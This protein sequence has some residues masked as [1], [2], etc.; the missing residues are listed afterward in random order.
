MTATTRLGAFIAALLLCSAAPLAA[1]E[2]WTWNRQ[3]AAGQV[4]EIKGVNGAI[5]AQPGTGS[6]VRVTAVKTARRDDVSTVRME[7]I[8]HAGGV[9][10]C[11]VYPAARGRPQNECAVGSGGRMNVQDNDVQVEFTVHVPQGVN[12][13]GTSVNGLVEARNL[14]G[15]VAA[16]T[17]NGAID[18]VTSGRASGGTVNGAVN[19]SMGRADW[20]GTL[21]FE[22]VNGALTVRLPQGVSTAVNATTVNGSIHTDFPLQVQGRFGPRRVSGTIGAGGRTLDLT[23]VNGSINI[24]RGQ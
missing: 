1:Q 2:T 17:V 9:T 24:L 23:T 14:T 15:D 8:E 19:V 10:I 7:V 12:F 22:T 18:I 21:S 13:T 6:Q 16:R 3:L 4:I 20:A 11:A 5:R